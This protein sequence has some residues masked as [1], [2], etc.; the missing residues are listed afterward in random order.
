[1][2]PSVS[3]GQ[4]EADQTA[5]EQ[6][7]AAHQAFRDEF[8]EIINAMNLGSIEPFVAAID[9]NDLLDRI[10]GLRLIDQKVK[11]QFQENFVQDLPR[12]INAEVADD[13]GGIRATLLGFASRGD[14]GR[15]V[16][17]YDYANFQ[18]NYHEYDLRRE[19]KGRPIII[20]WLDFLQGE[21]FSEGMGNTLIMALPSSSA[22]RKLVDFQNISEHEI[23]QMTEMLKA[24]RDR[25]KD[26]Y[27]EIVAGFDE[28]FKRQR[29]VVLTGVQLTKAV[30]DRRK[31][32]TALVAMAKYFPEEPLYT[33][34]LLDYYFPSKKYEE[35][36]QSLLRLEQRLGV[37]DAAM[38]ARLSAAALVMGDADS[39]NL[40]AD[41]AIVLEPGLELGWWSAIR[42]RLALSEFDRSIE[43]LQ[44]LE[45]EF[46]H[47]LGPA[48]LEGQKAFQ[49]LLLS[50][51]YKAWVATRQ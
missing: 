35:A 34:M 23:F 1:M 16:V 44:Q 47:V 8:Q 27:F 18:F 38:K 5:A 12:M 41:Q 45:Q 42:A 14:K 40:Y 36:M 17:R 25:R 48:E 33:L 49:E 26:K 19:R 32:R 10:Y 29:I 46:G 4:V 28:K 11:K 13:E 31:M 50:E 2:L 22:V 6:E 9:H 15:A 39:A 3:L 37:E 7:A 21:R 30:R 51:E 24:V 43:A 20:D